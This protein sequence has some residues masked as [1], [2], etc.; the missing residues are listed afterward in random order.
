MLS[1]PLAPELE[2]SGVRMMRL[3]KLMIRNLFI[4]LGFYGLYNAVLKFIALFGVRSSSLTILFQGF[5]GNSLCGFYGRFPF[6]FI[7]WWQGIS[8]H[9]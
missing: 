4:V 9:M 3:D 6:G 7:V 5:P 1:I 2:R 8:F